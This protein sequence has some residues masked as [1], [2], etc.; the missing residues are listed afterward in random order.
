MERRNGY[1]VLCGI[2]AAR[3]QEHDVWLQQERTELSVSCDS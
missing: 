1:D 3:L 2:G